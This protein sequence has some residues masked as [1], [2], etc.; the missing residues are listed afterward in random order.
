MC[1]ANNEKRK[2]TNGRKNKN[3]K[4]RKYQMSQ[5]SENI[6]ILRNTVSG[7]RQTCGDERK[8]F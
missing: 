3:T 8:T 4:S 7:Q 1:N 5:R 6:Q 2:T